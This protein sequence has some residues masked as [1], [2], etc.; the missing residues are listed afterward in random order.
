MDFATKVDSYAKVARLEDD[1]TAEAFSFSMGVASNAEA[2]LRNL[3]NEDEATA[4]S[5]R[6]LKP[7]FL[8]RFAPNLTASEKAALVERL[9][10]DK[11]EDV[12]SFLDRCK[13][14]QFLVER[15]IPEERR[16]GEHI[17]AAFK[18]AHNDGVLQSFF[19]VCARL[20]ALRKR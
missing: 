11:H 10:Q 20:M 18:A 19:A 2:W 8:R 12:A 17:A 9:R 16:V 4:G 1:E 15:D 5:W 14:V 13:E 7:A 6:R 3:R